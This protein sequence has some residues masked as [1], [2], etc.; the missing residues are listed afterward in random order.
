MLVLKFLC[1]FFYKIK[2]FFLSLTPPAV[3]VD[4]ALDILSPVLTSKI[5]PRDTQ[6]L[7]SG[8]IN[9]NLDVLQKDLSSIT[10][11]ASIGKIHLFF[12]LKI[13]FLL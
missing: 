10:S 5:S 3:V 8:K 6:I 4:S 13:D 9:T 7:V 2:I 1:F 12:I 11:P